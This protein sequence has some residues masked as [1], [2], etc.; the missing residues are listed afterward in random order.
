MT[1]IVS[2]ALC[3]GLVAALAGF[4]ASAAAQ[5]QKPK[6]HTGTPLVF[7]Q[8]PVTEQERGIDQITCPPPARPTCGAN[9]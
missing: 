5:T 9:R 7:Q 2:A 3:I 6:K 8:R 1:R 4:G